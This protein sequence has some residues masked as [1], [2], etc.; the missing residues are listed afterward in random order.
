[1][2]RVIVLSSLLALVPAMAQTLP[3]DAE[4]PPAPTPIKRIMP[5]YP[6]IA[7]YQG[8]SGEAIA[9]ITI[10]DD[11]E[12]ESVRLVS[13]IPSDLGFGN[14]AL[15]SVRGWLYPEGKSGTYRI[16]IR[17]VPA[18]DDLLPEE[19]AMSPAGNPVKRV[20]PRY[21]RLAEQRGLQGEAIMVVIVDAEG[22]V[23]STRL[24]H[25][26][27]PGFDFGKAALKAAS[28]WRFQPGAPGFA[29]LTMRFRFEGY[30]EETYAFALSDLKPAPQP[31]TRK[32]PV[33]P[34]DALAAGL[35][36]D[37]IIAIYVEDGRVTRAA[38]AAE[39][40]LD[41]KFGE[42]AFL[43]VM[44]WRF[45]GAPDGPYRVDIPFRL[46]K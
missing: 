8:I 40:P 34:P 4:L 9:D 45:K 43:A 14:A 6:G 41:H 7:Y 2:L 46:P 11:G 35:E 28:K 1:M 37:A 26:S 31:S 24:V 33:Y 25:E 15:A 42:A 21:P 19:K 16:K 39:E 17:F 27:P 32:E 18:P 22:N 13:E 3:A 5:E 10:D 44:N 36:G 12:V 20:P 29:T 38:V 30:N 23:T